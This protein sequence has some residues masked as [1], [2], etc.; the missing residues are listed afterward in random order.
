MPHIILGTAGH[1]DHGKSSLVKALTGIDP[2]RLK[3][4]KERG[5]TIDLGFAYLNYPDGLTVG[6]VD[7]PG[8]ER[9]VRNMLAGAAGIDMVLFVIAADEGIMPQSREHLAICNLLKIKSGLVA[10]NKADLVEP[11]WLELVQEEIREFLKGS[12]LEGADIIPVSAKTGLNIELLKEK[13]KEIALKVPQ[14]PS[15]GAF[16][17]PVDRVFTLKGFGTVVTGT[18]ISGSVRVDDQVEIL[19]SGLKTKIRGIQ[20]HGKSIT[21]GFA[22]QRLALNL[23]GVEKEELER[24]DIV[25]RPDTFRPT[26][27]LNVRI[28]ILK[29][30]PAIKNRSLVHLHIWTSEAIAR[31][32]L[33]DRDELKPGSNAYAQLRLDRDVITSA[34]DRFVIR[35]ISPLD[36]I[37]GGVVLDPY[38]SRKRYPELKDEL[39]I[40]ESA[41]LEEKI[42]LKVKRS[43]G[44]PKKELY[45]WINRELKDIE[46]ALKALKEKGQ[47][48]EIDGMLFHKASIEDIK[49]KF[50]ETIREFHNK[51]PLK[52]GIQKEELRTGSGMEQKIFD[53]II[54]RTPEIIRE[55]EY[56]RLREF[57]TAAVDPALKE[58][59]LNMIKGG[60][61]QPPFKEELAETINIDA[62]KLD[63][64]LRLLQQEGLLERINDSFYLS[65]E[66]HLELFRRLNEFFSKKKELTVSD[67]RDMLQTTRK[68]AIPL[69]EYLDSKK[70]TMRV[71]DVRKLLKMPKI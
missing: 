65:R 71:G 7:V 33:F 24:G 70:I 28:E 50:I 10:L 43:K 39:P 17:L 13:I 63:D 69:L 1:I 52:P 64:I 36:T 47:V 34:E 2:D 35:R 54:E 41:E 15:G 45:G 22:G 59:I 12:F 6:I 11:E 49:N 55:G 67:F 26:R 66:S 40:F 37:G 19:P 58:R 21:E 38:P 29:D 60:A 9:L 32:I 46:N 48:V 4:E 51:N 8:H 42:A 61:F 56:L 31:L 27:L 25:A 44:F 3:E 62:R 20:S 30:A 23:Q 53:Y 57:R 68:Y 18:A 14:K 16:R 5:I